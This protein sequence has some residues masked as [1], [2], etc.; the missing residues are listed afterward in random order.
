MRRGPPA[1]LPAGSRLASWLRAGARSGPAPRLVL[2]TYAWRGYWFDRTWRQQEA[3]FRVPDFAG[4]G[5]R[6]LVFV[7]GFWRSGTTLLHELLASGP[8]MAAP[9]TWQCMNPSGFRIGGAP[10]SRAAVSRPMDAVSVSALSPQE[11]EFVLLARGAPSV[12]R[13]WL[14]P[15]R[16][17]ETLPALRQET[18]L[19]LPEQ[20]WLGDWRTFLG[21]C[22]PEGADTLVVKSPNH[23]FRL[24]ALHRLWP[25]ARVV[26][27]LRDPADTWHSNRRMWQAMTAM[28]GLWSWP[29]GALDRLLFEAMSEYAAALRWAAAT[30]GPDTMACVDFERL[31]RSGAEVLRALT[32]R[33]DL[34]KWESWQPTVQPLLDASAGHAPESYAQAAPLPPQ[35][36]ALVE[37]V[38]ELHARLAQHRGLNTP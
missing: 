22:T 20:E 11:D 21:W 28:Y 36:G 13:A 17:Q 1:V 16:W 2:W 5:G 12:Y 24:Q 33:L 31:S 9:R 10:V 37:Q 23:V 3:L 29:A 32:G 38:R 14:D 19:S 4:E 18:W 7:L 15:R 25:K 8:R 27:T 34:G 6:N 35:A 26:W 30:L